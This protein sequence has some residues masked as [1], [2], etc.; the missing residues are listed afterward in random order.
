MVVLS[1]GQAGQLGFMG[2]VCQ[3]SG[4]HLGQ[5]GHVGAPHVILFGHKLICNPGRTVTM[6]AYQPCGLIEV[7]CVATSGLLLPALVSAAS[8]R[9]LSPAEARLSLQ[10][11]PGH[12]SCA[13]AMPAF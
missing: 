5:K 9:A 13:L 7:T 12:C 3:A 1:A 6:C 10:A 2:D 11:L 4:L 8:K